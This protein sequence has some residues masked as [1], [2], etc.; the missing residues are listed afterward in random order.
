MLIGLNGLARCGKS[1]VGDILAN[2]LGCETYALA[3][4]I[5]HYVNYMFGWD[6]RCSDGILKEEV[7]YTRV[8][9]YKSLLYKMKIFTQ[10]LS[11]KVDYKL[12]RH[13][14]LVTSF[15]K[16]FSDYDIGG[17]D[18]L[19]W[20]ISPRKAYQ[21]FGTEFGRN[22][23][24]DSL[25]IDVAPK[26]KVVWVDVRFP[27]E[28]KSLVASQGLLIH[29]ER[30]SQSII[31]ESGHESEMGIGNVDFFDYIVNDGTLDKLERKVETLSHKIKN[32][33]KLEG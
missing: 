26:E 7:I 17:D 23:I 8:I 21:L 20:A 29:I 30:P 1:T 15:I 9:T 16:V 31:A 25:W 4:P 19:Q 13:S 24:S 10:Y 6:C 11:S 28:V 2:Q 32:L 14:D 12:P 5:K 3:S 33:G 22:V 27:N 18:Y